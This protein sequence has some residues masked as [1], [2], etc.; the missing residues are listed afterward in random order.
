MYLYLGKQ[1]IDD[2]E[3]VKVTSAD[4]LYDTDDNNF[5]EDFSGFETRGSGKRAFLVRMY[6]YG[7]SNGALLTKIAQSIVKRYF[8]R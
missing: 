6:I 2:G 7:N 1:E 3:K 5:E 8:R 4:Y